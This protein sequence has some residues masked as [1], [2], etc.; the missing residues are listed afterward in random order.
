MCP[1]CLAAAAVVAVKAV[2]AGGAGAVVASK[3]ARR[4]KPKKFFVELKKREK[5]R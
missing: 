3:I 4:G 2:M 1:F 5:R